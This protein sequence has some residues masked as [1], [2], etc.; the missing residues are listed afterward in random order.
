M[1]GRQR[2][3]YNPPSFR[4][5]P[6]SRVWAAILTRRLSLATPVLLTLLSAF[7]AAQPVAPSPPTIYPELGEESVLSGELGC[8]DVIS[9]ESCAGFR[10][11]LRMNIGGY[12]ATINDGESYGDWFNSVTPE[13]PEFY[14]HDLIPS[15]GVTVIGQ[16]LFDSSGVINDRPMPRLKLGISELSFDFGCLP[17]PDASDVRFASQQWKSVNYFGYGVTANP[18]YRQ[19]EVTVIGG[20]LGGAYWNTRA[21][22][23]AIGPVLKLGKVWSRGKWLID[24][25]LSAMVGYG[26][27]DFTQN[28]ALGGG[29]LGGA[30]YNQPLNFNPTYFSNQAE[31]DFFAWSAGIN[32]TA[33][34]F[35][36]PNWSIDVSASGGISGPYYD[37]ASNIR[38]RLPDMGFK[39]PKVRDES[40]LTGSV[41][42][43]VSYVW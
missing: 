6:P 11:F 14:F 7:A 29:T 3:W 28:G 13:A 33:S 32:L 2:S 25:S 39:D 41:S 8:A 30:V 10:P 24:G 31:E 12:A 18:A 5:S 35:I 42:L 43:G 40:L 34:Y 27:V 36:K 22:Q 23:V 16:H 26:H 4:T 37:A 17:L 38:Y 15:G 1:A 20:V 9:G 21:E 19:F